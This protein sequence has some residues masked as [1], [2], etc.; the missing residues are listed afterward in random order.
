[1]NFPNINLEHYGTSNVPS[2]CVNFFGKYFKLTK[3]ASSLILQVKFIMNIINFF[4]IEKKL[5]T[6]KLYFQKFLPLR[7]KKFIKT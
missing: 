7:E 5:D 1:M 4:A 2:K 6:P 3:V